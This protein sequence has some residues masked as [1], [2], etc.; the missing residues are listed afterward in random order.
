MYLVLKTL[1][2]VAVVLFLGN[3][4]TGVFWKLNADRGGDPGLIAAALEGILRADR[5]FTA[6]GA[7]LILLTGIALAWLGGHA[8][9]TTWIWAGLALFIASAVIF[10]RWAEPAQRRML[11][12][13]RQA[14]FDREE[15]ARHSRTWMWSGT[16]ATLAP[17]VALA[18]M[19][20]KPA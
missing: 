9:F 17:Y 10:K 5:W 8:F 19:V 20:F 7:T 3:I 1:H 4:T 11:A 15:Y 6:P 13:A 14:P 16:L 2:I 12:V 18:L